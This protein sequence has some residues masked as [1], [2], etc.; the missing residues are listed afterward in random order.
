MGFRRDRA[1]NRG[2]SNRTLLKGIP[3]NAIE[4][5]GI[6]ADAPTVTIAPTEGAPTEEP[7]IEI[8]PN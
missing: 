6:V 8:E 1:D 7:V 4:V 3:P 2:P 5:I